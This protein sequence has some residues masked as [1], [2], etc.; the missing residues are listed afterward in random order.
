VTNMYYMFGFAN[1]FSGNLSAWDISSVTNMSQ[2]FE[3]VTLSIE[4]YD[5]LLVSWSNQS[6][7]SDVSFNA[8]NSDYSESSQSARDVLTGTYNWTITDGDR[9]EE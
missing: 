6:L 5:A 1:A 8:G 3:S 9:I 4:N 2:M 7:Q